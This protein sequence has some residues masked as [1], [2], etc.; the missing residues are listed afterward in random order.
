MSGLI[1]SSADFSSLQTSYDEMP[2]RPERQEQ[3][4]AQGQAEEAERPSSPS[5]SLAQMYAAYE[6]YANAGPS[7]GRQSRVEQSEEEGVPSSPPP[8]LQAQLEHQTPELSPEA[9][10]DLAA[11]RPNY[12]GPGIPQNPLFDPINTP[13]VRRAKE[14][15]EARYKGF[16]LGPLASPLAS[17]RTLMITG[18]VTSAGAEAKLY[19]SVFKTS[20]PPTGNGDQQTFNHQL[21]QMVGN[22]PHQKILEQLNNGAQPAAQSSVHKQ[23]AFHKQAK[24]QDPSRRTTDALIKYTPSEQLKEAANAEDSDG[25]TPIALAHEGLNTAYEKGD[26]IQRQRLTHFIQK[27]SKAAP[28]S[29]ENE[30][31][32]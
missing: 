3:A 22:A 18:S 17:A 14:Q 29:K 23:N 25:K 8:D 24:S 31:V 6:G 32:N 30:G 5:D 10:A 2:E 7:D 21:R 28:S 11:Q 27:L 13:M 9:Q 1:E 19:R 26:D 12:Q 16:H 15:L 4:K 20:P